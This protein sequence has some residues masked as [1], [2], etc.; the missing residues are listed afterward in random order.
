MRRRLI[1]V[2]LAFAILIVGFCLWLS[3]HKRPDVGPSAA[4]PSTEAARLNPDPEL[5]DGPAPAPSRA[6]E[7]ADAVEPGS[8]GH[9]D[10]TQAGGEPV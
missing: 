4:E 1:P 9:G 7:R 2:L 3:L 5:R 10:P 6:E 8:P